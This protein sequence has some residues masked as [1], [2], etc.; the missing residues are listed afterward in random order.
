MR[1]EVCDEPTVWLR[2]APVEG[3]AALQPELDAGERRVR[4]EGL[5]EQVG[6]RPITHN[7]GVVEY[8]AVRIVV[9][10]AGRIVEQGAC[11]EVLARPARYYTR[12]LLAAVPQLV[13]ACD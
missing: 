7:I 3:L 9:M 6:L 10:K 2:C 12:Q 11:A 8:V 4:L 1:R 5:T 13:T